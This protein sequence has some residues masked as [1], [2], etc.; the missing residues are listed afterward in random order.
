MQWPDTAVGKREGRGGEGKVDVSFSFILILWRKGIQPLRT[1]EWG[2]AVWKP[3]VRK[4]TGFQKGI[5]WLWGA[6]VCG[7]Q[8]WL[9]NPRQTSPLKTF[10]KAEKLRTPHATARHTVHAVHVKETNTGGAQPG[11][12]IC[13]RALAEGRK[14]AAP[15]SQAGSFQRTQK[16]GTASLFCGTPP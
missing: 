9:K 10:G 2:E 6:G 13:G 5:V 3:E 16:P 12:C 1:F 8:S 14:S 15:K 11:R 7:A 4:S